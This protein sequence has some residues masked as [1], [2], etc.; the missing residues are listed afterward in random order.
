MCVCVYIYIYS[1]ASET[2]GDRKWN[3]KAKKEVW[4]VYSEFGIS[5]LGNEEL[6]KVFEWR[7]NGMKTVV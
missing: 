1:K 4:P 6:R 2:R 7:R 3:D 5:L